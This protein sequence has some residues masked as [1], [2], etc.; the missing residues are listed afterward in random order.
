MGFESLRWMRLE[1][2][3]MPVYVREDPPDWFVPN[4]AADQALKSLLQGKALNGDLHLQRLL[5]RVDTGPVKDYQGRGQ[6]LKLD[7]LREVWFH[8]TDRCNLLCSHCLV[9]SGPGERGEMVADR[10]EGIAGQA[11]G[12]GARLFALTGGEP[13]MHGE[14]RRIIEALLALDGTNVVILTNGTLLTHHQRDLRKWPRDRVHLQVSL[15]GL[16]ET[17]DRIR[18]SG[19]FGR[20][21]A[22][23]AWLKAEEIPYTVSMCVIRENLQEMEDVVD[24]AARI[25]AGNVHF[26]WG[27]G[28]GRAKGAGT[29]APEAAFHQMRRAADKAR[30][31]GMSIDNIETLRAQVFAPVGTRYDGSV[32]G[33]ESIAVGPDGKVYPTP[34]TVGIEAL[35]CEVNGN[36]SEAWQ[37]NPVLERLRQTTV[38]TLGMPLRYFLGGGDFDH[39]YVFS[40][41]LAGG[42]P[43]YPL[44]LKTFLWL[45]TQEAASQRDEGP[46]ALRLKMGEVLESCGPHGAVALVHNNCLLSVA[47]AKGHR[48]VA[49]F[50]ADAARMP[51]EEILNPVQYPE[52]L[53]DHISDEHLVR[54]YG[55]GSPV[56]DAR[57]Q[58]GECVLD[59][60]CGGGVECYIAARLVGRGG[61]VIGL[62]MLGEMLSLAG[63]GRT[64]VAQA[65]GYLNAAF[66][67]GKL[68]DLPLATETIDVVIS[69]CVINLSVNKRKVFREISRVLKRGGRVVVSDVVCEREPGPEIRNDDILKGQCLAG[70]MVQQDLF[71]LVEESGLISLRVLGRFPY[72]NVKGHP[73]YSLTFEAY[74]PG[75]AERVRVIYRGPHA[76]VVTHHGTV[77]NAGAVQEVWRDEV[78][79]GGDDILELDENGAVLNPGVMSGCACGCEVI[80]A[81]NVSKEGGAAASN[82][83]MGKAH[84]DHD[85]RIG[86]GQRY[87][88]DCM[89]CGAPL[90]Y[91]TREVKRVCAICGALGA[92][93]AFCANDHYVCDD[94]HKAEAQ[95]LVE[96]ICLSS[97]ETDMIALMKA[98]RSHAFF[99]VHGPE[100][101]GM[102][103]GVVLSAYRNIGG[104]ATDDMVRLGIERGGRVS[105][106]ACAFLGACG[107]ALGVGVAFGLILESNPLK[108]EARQIVQQVTKEA[109]AGIASFKAA[110]CCQR[111]TW[112]GLRT[113][114]ELSSRYLPIPLLAEAPLVCAQFKKNRECIGR[115]CPL[116]PS[117]RVRRTE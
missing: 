115:V 9:S 2:E 17:H 104:R 97:S 19:T 85:G 16:E 75:M 108:A 59:L 61:R 91:T 113:A 34:A 94:C 98:I 8:V 65:L 95:T 101:H 27:F 20:L 10:I 25:G 49:S 66:C 63:R 41:E 70:A 72:R 13:F 68:E 14:I 78:R 15:D 33:W 84:P 99:P 88:V 89:V 50:Y 73:F 102:V 107:G 32:A 52:A 106:G 45:I 4:R 30:R 43:Y 48:P 47:D 31:V 39:S 42:D 3:G 28:R 60:G 54:R 83:T 77:L 82:A 71:G 51:N 53:V 96:R 56:V 114:A 62:D 22:G 36:L 12:L 58:A 93:N 18:G 80:P 64:Y 44:Y 116:Y 37:E 81:S 86:Q 87:S 90:T 55:C 111:D 105:G 92:S 110:R 112:L 21:M 100:H 69:N 35:G 26:M 6:A 7:R 29:V 117:R 76:S 57:L 79:G 11:H 67:G 103:A 46:P 1:F 38:S 23:L 5:G 74:K 40:G 109:L 24:L